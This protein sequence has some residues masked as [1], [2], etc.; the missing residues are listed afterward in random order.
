MNSYLVVDWIHAFD[1]EPVR[2]YS[3]L[4]ESRCEIRKIEIYRDGS[5][6]I[7]ISGKSTKG[8]KLSLTP[9]PMIDEINAQS[10][11]MA[12]EISK[13]EFDNIWNEHSE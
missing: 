8:S 4:D 3:E 7:A 9:I 13:E 12:T 2:L 6:G 5:F 10:E 1:D 11:F